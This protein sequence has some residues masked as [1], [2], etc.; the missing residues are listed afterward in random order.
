MEGW[1][2]NYYKKD[3]LPKLIG[4]TTPEERKYVLM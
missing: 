2:N 3:I 4:L 1:G